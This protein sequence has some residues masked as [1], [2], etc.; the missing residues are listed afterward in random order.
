MNISWNESTKEQKSYEV[1]VKL[2]DDLLKSEQLVKFTSARRK[3][4]EHK[5]A[6]AVPSR[7]AAS[8]K[9]NCDQWVD[10]GR[11][12]RGE[13]MCS[14]TRP[15]EQ[16]SI[17][18]P[19]AISGEKRKREADLDGEDIQGKRKQTCLHALQERVMQQSPKLRLLA[20]SSL[21]GPRGR[22]PDSFEVFLSNP[23]CIS[24]LLTPF[25]AKTLST[26]T[27]RW[28]FNRLLS[29]NFAVFRGLHSFHGSQE[30]RLTARP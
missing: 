30:E 10:G 26:A 3:K 27:A 12:S 29:S 25:F 15:E 20:P 5:T 24:Y 21:H 8:K 4:I 18:E 1:L 28:P 6:R 14:Q 9:G 13:K 19:M 16:D 7:K 23:A 11:S 17:K 22:G 2:V